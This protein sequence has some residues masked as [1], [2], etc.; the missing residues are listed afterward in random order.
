MTEP[1]ETPTPPDET[2]PMQGLVV[3]EA[4]LAT[5]PQ[6]PGVYRML[7]AKGDALYV[8]KARSLKKRVHAYTQV[9]R[10]PE[11][12]RR[13][14][15]ETRSLEVM[16]TGSEAEALLLEAN[17]IKRMRP[18]FNIVLRDD[19]SYPWLVMTEDHPYPQIAKH[20]GERRKGASYWGP[21]ASAWAVNQTLTALQRV[22]LLRSC[23]DTV[24][25]SRTRPCLLHQIKRCSAPCVERIGREDYAA[26]VREAKDFLSGGAPSLQQTLAREMEEAAG[27]LEFERA[28]SIRDRIRGLTFV[29]GK[30]RI[31]L[32]GV[33]D[34]D[35]V[36]LHQMAGQSCVQVFFFRGGRNNGNR[37]FF[38]SHAK[39]EQPPEEV[40]AAFIAQL[41]DDLPPPPLVLLSHD[42]QDAAL[43]AE[44]LTLKA[45]RKVELH[46]PQRGE[47]KA[48]VEHA[49]TNAREAIERRMAEGAA[50]SELLAGVARVFDL[51]DQPERIEV[52]DNSHIMGSNAYGVMIAAGPAGFL[53]SAYRKYAIKGA[54]APAP[55]AVP[56]GGDDFAMMREVFERRFGRALREDPGRD[57]ESWPDLVLIDG[58]AGQLSAAREVLNEMG[59]HDIPLVGIAKGPDR[60]AGR[61]WFHQTGKPPFQ[62]P[63]RDA[64]LYYL[65]RLRD[66]AH[67]FAL[68][69][70]RA[71][72][73]KT[74]VR[75]EL[76]DVPGVGAAIKRR[77][78]NHF[79]SARGVRQAGL[80]DL[81]ACPGI[82]PAVARR[83]HG[84]FHPG[85]GT[86]RVA[87]G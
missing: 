82:G 24:F 66:E 33:N 5:L 85:A 29:Q 64:V 42:P 38:L 51:A 75:S 2:A 77:L 71:G 69:T 63:A 61:E 13:M 4:A 34:A 22:F 68:S 27:R 11:R 43:I 3:I 7:N 17:L 62:L 60:D 32:D 86:G 81:E 12:L 25:D 10:L 59:L 76:D 44:A 36:A 84:H 23:R 78:L 20:R 19:K 73:S 6:S 79:G 45:G 58:G 35:V 67:R 47:R 53:K 8:G 70:H 80:E 16:T 26:L 21:F 72:R 49:A 15:F 65:Q 40:I 39:S 56:R 30:D 37:P 48:A 41:Y 31:H 1:N 74:L 55:A 50:Q 54:V 14:V 28:A 83:I 9:A 46:R 52:F 57:A 87:E 18:R